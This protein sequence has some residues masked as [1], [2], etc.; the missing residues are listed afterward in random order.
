MAI[1]LPGGFNI[2]NNEPVDARLTV[3]NEA[4]RLGFSAANVYEGL[5]VYQQDNN[6]LYV[7]TDATAPGVNGS[8]TAVMGAGSTPFPYTGSARITGSLT[9]VGNTN[10]TGSIFLSNGSYSGSGANL[11]NIPASAVID[12][13]LSRIHTGSVTASVNP[14]GTIFL[15]QSSSVDLFGVNEEGVVMLM[16]TSTTPTHVVGGLY[17]STSG[18]LFLGV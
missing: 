11:F 3:A 18:D 15:I 7:L 2:L 4:A 9:V 16:P 8:W 14:T 10:I 1:L 13:D 6:Q 17:Y 5:V 12:L